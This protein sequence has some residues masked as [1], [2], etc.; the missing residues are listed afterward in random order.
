[1]IKALYYVKYKRP[2]FFQFNK[3]LDTRAENCQRD[4]T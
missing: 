3:F 2:L 4:M 1:M